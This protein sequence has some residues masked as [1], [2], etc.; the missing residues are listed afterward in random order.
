LSAVR[1]TAAASRRVNPHFDVADE[2]LELRLRAERAVAP[3][4][5]LAAGGRTARVT[6]GGISDR[7][8]AIGADLIVDTRIDP[9]F[10]RSAVYVAV[11]REQLRFGGA[12]AGRWTT[13]ARGYAAVG[14]AFVIALRA[15]AATS[16]RHLP[17]SEQALL[18]GSDTLRGYPAGVQAGDNLAA[19][20]AEIRMPLNSPLR[21]GRFGIK[22]FVD[23]ATTWAVGE[24]LGARRFDRGIGG[25]IY[26]GGGPI[27]A[28]IA[29]A[30]PEH[31]KP[32]FHAA[33]GMTF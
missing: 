4:L 16:D 6:F 14:G 12:S 31:G 29:L 20:S 23:A 19:V 27:V 26:F 7:H 15:Q 8:R 1:G 21:V 28:D 22:G 5:R 18:G 25:G 11:G 33:L 24:R 13:D 2:R 17:P 30:W 10:P 32:H 9:S 3:W